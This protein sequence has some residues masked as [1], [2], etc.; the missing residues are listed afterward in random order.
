MLIGE[1]SKEYGIEIETLRYYDR[2][3]LLTIER[4]KNNRHYT[5]KDIKKLQNIMAMKEMMFTL[6]DIKKLLEIDERID[7]GLENKAI[8]KEDINTL[9]E[10]VKSKHLEILEKEKQLKKVKKHLEK[11]IGKIENLQRRDNSD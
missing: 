2:I 8:N 10:G 6:E 7:R 9:L 3:G 4:R 11:I 5:E 1:V